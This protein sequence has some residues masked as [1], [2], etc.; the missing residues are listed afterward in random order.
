MISLNYDAASR[1]VEQEIDGPFL[2]ERAP[3]RGQARQPEQ[4]RRLVFAANCAKA[5]AA[6]SKYGVDRNY[7]YL[8]PPSRAPTMKFGYG[9]LLLLYSLPDFSNHGIARYARLHNYECLCE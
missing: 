4:D 7:R 5:F 9:I 2:G 1:R 6:P 8:P 3:G